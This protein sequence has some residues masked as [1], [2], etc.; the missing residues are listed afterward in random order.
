MKKGKK[1]WVNDFACTLYF[2]GATRKCFGYSIDHLK[3][4]VPEAIH[5]QWKL[6]ANLNTDFMHQVSDNEYRG[7]TIA[8]T[9]ERINY[10]I[11]DRKN[12]IKEAAMLLGQIGGQAGTGKK[13][14]RGDSNYYRV[15]RMKGVE[16]NKQKMRENIKKSKKV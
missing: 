8:V 14:V 13:K 4:R 2:L 10:V 1:R 15:L 12:R 5:R 7:Y 16:K 9:G 11:I 3:Q 6:R